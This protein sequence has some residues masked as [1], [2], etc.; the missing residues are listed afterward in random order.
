[1][2]PQ[3]RA[4]AEKLSSALLSFS[5][6]VDLLLETKQQRGAP[7]ELCCFPQPGQGFWALWRLQA[8]SRLALSSLMDITLKC[9]L[10]SSA[11]RL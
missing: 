8:H 6:C 7:D 1:M 11:D 5:L 9:K 3:T 4:T 10:L 2:D